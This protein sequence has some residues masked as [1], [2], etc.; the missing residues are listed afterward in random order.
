[1]TIFHLLL[2]SSKLAPP[3]YEGSESVGR[4]EAYKIV[5]RLATPP[6]PLCLSSNR[7]E[8]QRYLRFIQSDSKEVL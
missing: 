6:P 3:E 7:E 5:T 8:L 2:S 4:T 1:M